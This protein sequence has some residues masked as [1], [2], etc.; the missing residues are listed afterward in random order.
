MAYR[1]ARDL[2]CKGIT[3]YRD[4][5]KSQQ[6]LYMG[7]KEKKPV[8]AKQATQELII[9]APENLLKVDSTYDPACISGSCS[10]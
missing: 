1:L 3:V 7:T 2:H 10:L 4:G 9:S 6:V 8:D 5:S